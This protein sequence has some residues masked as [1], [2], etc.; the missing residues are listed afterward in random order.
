[1]TPEEALM[2]FGI[3]KKMGEPLMI[4]IANDDAETPHL[5]S[6]IVKKAWTN[7]KSVWDETPAWNNKEV[8]IKLY[9][10]YS[11]ALKFANQNKGLSSSHIDPRETLTMALYPEYIITDKFPVHEARALHMAASFGAE[12]SK[13]FGNYLELARKL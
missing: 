4:Y 7:K 8:I 1:M 2:E 6:G 3:S 10:F 11:I 9:P 13:V 12:R 5:T